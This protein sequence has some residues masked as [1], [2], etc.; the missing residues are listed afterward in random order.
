MRFLQCLQ[1][2]RIWN[3]PTALKKPRILKQWISA[4]SLEQSSVQPTVIHLAALCA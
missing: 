3:H 1:A 4:A 2:L